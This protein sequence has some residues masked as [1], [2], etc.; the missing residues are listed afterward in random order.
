MASQAKRWSSE[1]GPIETRN[2][3]GSC[4]CDRSS[5]RSR[6]IEGGAGERSFDAILAWVSLGNEQELLSWAFFEPFKFVVL[7]VEDCMRRP[8]LVR[9]ILGQLDVPNEDLHSSFHIEYRKLT[10]ITNSALASSP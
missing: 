3:A 7:G 1:T 8:R 9:A 10:Q 4:V 6:L 5:W 2:G